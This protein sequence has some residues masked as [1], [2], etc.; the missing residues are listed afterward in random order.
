MPESKFKLVQ[1]G[2][3]KVGGIYPFIKET[4]VRAGGMVKDVVLGMN[5]GL[6]SIFSLVAGVSAGT[7]GT[8]AGNQFVIIAGVAGAIAGA[9][10]MAFGTYI[11]NKSQNEFYEEEFNREREEIETLSEVEKEEIRTLYRLKGFKGKQLEGAV[12]T[13]TSNKDVWLRVMMLEE[14]GLA[15]E[16]IQ[17]PVKLAAANG[18]AFAIASLFPIAPYFFLQNSQALL[19]SA[20]L[21]TVALFAA[22][23]VKSRF[24]QK[25]W[26]K[27]GTEMML[28]GIAAAAITYAVG[29]LFNVSIS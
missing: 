11:S 9:L 8:A 7:S 6:V 23:A 1:P 28:V 22:G 5:D 17:N 18:A 19:A 3:Q 15:E 12:K 13:I 21:S 20:V 16:N 24:T 4:H 27:S 2:A 26:L 25:N 10:S 14:L 29:W